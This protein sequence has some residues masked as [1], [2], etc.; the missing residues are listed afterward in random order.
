MYKQLI[1]PVFF[2]IDPE[3]VHH[4]VVSLVKFGFKI[5]GIQ[6]L[7]RKIFTVND[8]KLERKFF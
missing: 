6:P 2:C 1:R 4:I 5:P 7:V 8:P 3:K